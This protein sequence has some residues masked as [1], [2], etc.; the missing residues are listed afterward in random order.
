MGAVGGFGGAIACRRCQC[1]GGGAC[2]VVSAGAAFSPAERPGRLVGRDFSQ[3]ALALRD[4][5]VNVTVLRPGPSVT[6]PL[7]API[8]TPRPEG[9]VQFATPLAGGVLENMG[10]G[11]I[12]LRGDGFIVTNAHVVRGASGA[13]VTVFDDGGTRRYTARVIRLDERV[14][15]ALLHIALKTP[16][17]AVILGDSDRVRLAEEVISIG[18]PFGL[19]QTVS[20]GIVSGIRKALAIEGVTHSDLIQTDAA[21][22]QGNSGGPLVNGEGSVIGINTAIYT[23]TGAFSGIGFAIPSN[24]VRAFLEKEIGGEL[25]RPVAL[26]NANAAP[27]IRVGAVAPRTP[28]GGRK[29]TAWPAI[30]CFRRP[31]AWRGSFLRRSIPGRLGSTW[32]G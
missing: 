12:V 21:I 20:R 29:R 27:P 11:V 24:T 19:D 18:S 9:D 10:S 16:L 31:E 13:Q 25:A 30:R 3:I 5:V 17:P 26:P 32:R 22:N 15:L 6:A 4:S 1:P 7:T 23:P 8:T 14:D 2:R 28:T